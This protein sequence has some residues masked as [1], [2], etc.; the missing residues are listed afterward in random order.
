MKSSL[1]DC[2]GDSVRQTDSVRV[3]KNR[4]SGWHQVSHADGKKCVVV[5]LT[6]SGFIGF[7]CLS[8]KGLFDFDREGQDSSRAR[9][10]PCWR[11]W[12]TDGC[13]TFSPTS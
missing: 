3:S 13:C 4:Q 7:R 2:S 9:S 8:M 11:E 6:D 5:E 1:R 10:P 12:A